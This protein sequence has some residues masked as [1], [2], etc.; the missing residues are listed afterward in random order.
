M[1]IKILYEDKNFIGFYKPPKLP[2]SYGT[3][4]DS[5]VEQIK[6]NHPELFKFAGYN[7]EEGG[8]LYRL[9]N[10]ASG[11]LLFAKNKENFDKFTNDKNLEKIYIAEISNLPIR[12]EGIINYDIVHKSSKK[13]AA[14][15]EGKKIRYKGKPQ[16][17]ETRYELINRNNKNSKLSIQNSTFLK[18]Y[19]K[20]GARH[21]IRAH[22]ASIN[23]PI[24]GDEI[25]HGQPSETLHLYCVGIKSIFLN[26]DCTKEVFLQLQQ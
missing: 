20:K 12:K 22:L 25:Y 16:K 21:Q 24:I 5:F 14:L 4:S 8:L 11:L 18:C 2:S 6:K 1:D 19:I 10:E 9:D 23:C 13:M 15:I 3:E 17:A 26:I 7:K